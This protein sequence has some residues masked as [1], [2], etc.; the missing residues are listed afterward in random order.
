MNASAR[1]HGPAR[2]VTNPMRVR[3]VSGGPRWALPFL[4]AVLLLLSGGA[5]GRRAAADEP[6][7]SQEALEAA[8]AAVSARTDDEGYAAQRALAEQISDL[9]TPA[10]RQSL[11]AA[12]ERL[13]SGDRRRAAILL[14][15]WVRRGGPAD[16]DAA[17]AWVEQSRDPRLLDLLDRVVASALEPATRKHVWEDALARAVPNVRA[18][19]ARALGALGEPDSVMPLIAVLREPNFL[20]RIEVVGALGQ[21]KDAR[22]QPPLV[23]LLR[24]PDLRL[25]DASARALGVLGRTEVLPYLV[26]LLGDPASLV[27]EGAAQ[28]LGMLG[29]PAAVE[30]L[31]DRLAKAAD[32][33]LRV[34]DALATALER[35]TGQGFGVEVGAWRDWWKGAKDKPFVKP[36]TPAPGTTLAGPRYYGFPVRSS[37]V[38]FV[39]DVSRSMGWNGR[40][41]IARD[42][43]LQVL[44]HLPRSTRFNL[45]T[46]SDKAYPWEGGLVPATLANVHRAAAYVRRQVPISGTAAYEALEAAFADAEVDSIFFLS[47]GQPSGGTVVDPELI[48]ADVRGW[49]RYRRVRIHAVSLLRGEPPAAF[50][51]L[52]DPTRAEEF[53]RRLAAENDGRFKVVK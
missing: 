35:L 10:A 3:R 48:L 53:M 41:D 39:L 20:V 13:G 34:A 44:E 26:P 17:V 32:E 2:G 11:K 31:L 19:I 23:T 12:L 1:F 50:A 18:Q 14:S 9:R 37:K 15:A 24:D 40:L 22:A 6:P 45:I 4:G 16:L 27:V 21:L 33:D 29:S 49:N 46:F 36:A 25:R 8:Y 51:G 52:E 5:G 43:L 47:D 30:P 28:A 7:P 42:E 38:V